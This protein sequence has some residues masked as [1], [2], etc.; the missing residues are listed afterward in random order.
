MFRPASTGSW[1][2]LEDRATLIQSPPPHPRTG[3]PRWAG[4]AAK[5]LAGWQVDTPSGL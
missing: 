2:K 3:E 1:R 4:D 5:R